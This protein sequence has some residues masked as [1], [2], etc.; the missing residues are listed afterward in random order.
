MKS[1]TSCATSALRIAF[2]YRSHTLVVTLWLVRSK[3][4]ER[5]SQ[6]FCSRVLLRFYSRPSVARNHCHPANLPHLPTF[7]PPHFLI[8]CLYLILVIP[9]L[10]AYIVNCSNLLRANSKYHTRSVFVI[11]GPAI[12]VCMRKLRLK[13]GPMST[14]WHL[15]WPMIGESDPGT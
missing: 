12:T 8:H 2:R 15:S 4:V 14:I 11:D 6:F 10:Y 5:L 1:D 3:Q 13:G 9:P 7:P